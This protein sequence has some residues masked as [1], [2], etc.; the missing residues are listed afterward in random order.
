MPLPGLT[1]DI[2]KYAGEERSA[3]N[4]RDRAVA[5]GLKEDYEAKL[6]ELEREKRVLSGSAS[7]RGSAT[8]PGK[9]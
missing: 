5:K 4:D 7:G 3:T 9:T 2:A 6:K 1:A 8:T